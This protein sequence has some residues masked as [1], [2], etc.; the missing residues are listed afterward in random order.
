[1][2]MYKALLLKITAILAILLCVADPWV[3]RPSGWVY[4][5]NESCAWQMLSFANGMMAISRWHVRA[6]AVHLNT[7]NLAKLV[8]KITVNHRKITVF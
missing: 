2:R 7:V 6:H 3:P 8:R 1:M 5:S 4:F